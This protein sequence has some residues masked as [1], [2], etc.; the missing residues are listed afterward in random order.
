MTLVLQAFDG[1]RIA[2]CHW[3]EG[4]D[5]RPPRSQRPLALFARGR[6]SVA[7]RQ[8]LALVGS[9]DLSPV[10]L[11]TDV[12]SSSDAESLGDLEQ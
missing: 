9:D 2:A 5:A 7:L 11:P 4:A 1:D 12:E 8:L 10:P 6:G 3:L